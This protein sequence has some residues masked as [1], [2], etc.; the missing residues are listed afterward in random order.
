MA[1]MCLFNGFVMTI[2]RQQRHAGGATLFTSLALLFFLSC[3]PL[4]TIE[5]VESFA[6]TRTGSDT[7]ISPYGPVHVRFS[8]PVLD[9]DSVRFTFQP[10]FTEY[11]QTFNAT[12]DTFTLECILPLQGDEQYS[13][14]LVSFVESEDGSLLRPGEDTLLLRTFPA[15]QEPND[16][17]NTADTLK[18]I[19]FG[20]V[21]AANDTDW[22]AIHD[23]AAASFYLKSTGSSSL[24]ELR[25]AGSLSVRPLKFAAAETLDIPG[26]FER[27]VYITVFAYNRSN[28]GHYELGV[29]EK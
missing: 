2:R 26:S 9:P 1:F 13:L 23:T 28:G 15:E 6:M 11:R 4:A 25:D 27:P 29:V 8:Y 5:P 7:P 21:S 14:F 3:L 24:F 12:L 20:S 17:K 10:L 22:F 18:G 19:I 16:S